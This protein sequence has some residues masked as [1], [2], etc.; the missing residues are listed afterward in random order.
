[1]SNL[2]RLATLF[3]IVCI[4][5]QYTPNATQAYPKHTLSIRKDGMFA[6]CIGPS[7]YAAKQGRPVKVWSL[8][9]KGH[10][11]IHVLPEDASTKSGSAHINQASYQ[12]MIRMH[13]KRWLGRR[14]ERFIFHCVFVEDAEED[15]ILYVFLW[16]TL[17]YRIE[18]SSFYILY[19]F[20]RLPQKHNGFSV[21][22][23]VFHK[24]TY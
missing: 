21:F 22:L 8:L 12:K 19:S 16:K 2:Q 5:P 23:G 17:T 9:Y 11:C 15:T 7:L 14:I 13:A 18:Y 20:Q 3:F 10:L 1:M 6:D 4:R 24:N